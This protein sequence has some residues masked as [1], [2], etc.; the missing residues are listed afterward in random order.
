MSVK[1]LR[2]D[3]KATL[4]AEPQFREMLFR[5]GYLLTDGRFSIEDYPFYGIWNEA[6]LGSFSLLVQ[7]KQT[8]YIQSLNDLSVAIVGHAYNPFDMVCDENQLCLDLIHAYQRGL[9]EYFDKVSE[10]TGVHVIFLLDGNKLIACQ[11]AC[12]MTGCFFGKINGITCIA[13]QPQ[14]I[15]DLF[16][17]KM[18]PM[19]DKLVRSKCYNIGNR[20]LPGNVTPYKEIKRLGG[21]TFLQVENGFEIKRFYPT[22][23]HSEFATDEEKQQGIEQIGNL[24]HNG[25]ECC[26]KKWDRCTI[27]MSGGTDSKT[28]I[29][30]ANGL[31]DKFTYYSFHS[32]PQELVDAMGARKLCESLGLE[33]TIYPIPDKNEE[34]PNFDFIKK[35]LQH[36][37]SY[38][39]NLADHEIRKYIF[40]HDLD[41]YDIELK[42]WASEVARVFL[43][44]KYEIK[45]PDTLNERQLSVFQT[46]FFGHPKLLRW[47]DKEYYRFLR[48]IGL[49]KPL[50]NYEHT[51]SFYWEIRMGSWGVSV[52]SSQQLFHRISMPMNNRKILELFLS[53]PHEERKSDSVH[54]RVMS[55]ENQAVVDAKV[56]IANLYFHGYRIWMEKLFYLWRTLFYRPMK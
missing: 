9:S 30:C 39:K 35:I 48:E 49:E 12:G 27:S 32:K 25:I 10:L 6:K 47:C 52:T 5:R 54:K 18:D 19:V 42:S 8:F 53:F 31:Y 3:I 56:E 14:L 16:S 17:L 4:D 40:L 38:C 43:E 28:T 1:I 11:D 50:F 41:A 24:I 7:S 29:A 37:T 22:A 51:D 44:R 20:Y 15:A 33:H 21:N 23:P 46:R 13:E 36:N 45:M 34:V 2:D 26:S 55:Y